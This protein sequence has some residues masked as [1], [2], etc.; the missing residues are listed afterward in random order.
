MALLAENP[1][2]N[3]GRIASAA[4]EGAVGVGAPKDAEQF[5]GDDRIT[6]DR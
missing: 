3:V 6:A 4:A 5:P 2:E 1:D